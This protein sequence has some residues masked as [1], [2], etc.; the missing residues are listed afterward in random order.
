[1][2]VILVAYERESESAVERARLRRFR[3]NDL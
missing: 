2:G 3:R 1:M